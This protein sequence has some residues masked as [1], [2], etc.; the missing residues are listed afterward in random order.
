[1]R[2]VRAA[3]VTVGCPPVLF[4]R[5]YGEKVMGYA[6]QRTSP[7]DF[8]HWHID[9]GSHKF[10]QRQLVAVWYLCDVPGPGGETQFLYQDVSI[11]PEKGKLILFPPFWTHEH[12]GNRLEAGVK[13]IRS[14]TPTRYTCPHRPAAARSATAAGSGCLLL[15]AANRIQTM[16][17]MGIPSA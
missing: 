4:A 10:D 1:M 9:G 5:Y 12:R 16:L 13:Y 17:D 3:K 14:T 8:Y 15:V 7:G 11:T 6:I 2:V